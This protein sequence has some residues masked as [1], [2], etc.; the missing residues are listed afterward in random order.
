MN[1]AVEIITINMA[2]MAVGSDKTL[3]RTASLGS[4]VAIVIHDHKNQVGG[5][6]HTMLPSRKAAPADVVEEARKNIK[7]N[8]AVA[9]YADE[10]SVR[11]V[12]EVEKM[13]GK[14]ENF[15]AKLIGGAKMFRLLGGDDKGLG[16][17]NVE[18]ARAQLALLRIPVESEDVGGAVGRSVELNME[19]GLV[20]I[21]T[22]I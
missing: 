7:T 10:S 8:E 4:C 16:F 19:N 3:I 2:E 17:R 5:M 22:V 12:A 11:L 14:R 1:M 13:G 18:A 15:R 6:A 21:T 9:K 20:V